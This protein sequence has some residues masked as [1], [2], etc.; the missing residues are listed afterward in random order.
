MKNFD[1]FKNKNN[2]FEVFKNFESITKY[3]ETIGDFIEL[4]NYIT[5]EEKY[6]VI[7][8]DYFIRQD[9]YTK[10]QIVSTINDEQVKLKIIFNEELRSKVL[11]SKNFKKFVNEMKPQNIKKILNNSKFSEEYKVDGYEISLWIKKMDIKDKKAI[12]NNRTL[13]NN[14]NISEGD[15]SEILVTINEDT[16]KEKY[17]ENVSFSDQDKCYIIKSFSSEYL[18]KFIENNK[19]FIERNHILIPKIFKEMKYEKISEII[20]NFDKLNIPE[21]DKKKILIMLN[22]EYKEKLDKNRIDNKFIKV[23]DL[24]PIEKNKLIPDFERDLSIYKGLDE[25]LYINPFEKD[26]TLENIIK[27][28]QICPNIKIHDMIDLEQS[29]VE[30]YIEGESWINNVLSQ[31]NPK[32][33]DIQKLAYIDNQIGKKISYT[34]NFDT[35]MENQSDERCC[36]KIISSGYGVCNGISIIEKYMLKKVGIESEKIDSIEHSFLKIKDIEIPTEN[37]IVKGDTLVDPTWNLAEQRYNARP[38]FFCIS[39][40]EIREADFNADGIDS[41]S[42]KV[43]E[44]EKNSDNIISLDD[45]YLREIYKSIGLVR[46]DNAFPIKKLLNDINK[47]DKS[48]YSIKEQLIQR[49][50]SLKSYYPDFFECINSTMKILQ[51]IVFRN[52]E[53]FDYNRCIV[54]RVYDKNDKNKKPILFTYFDFGQ[55]KKI[56]YYADK[57]TKNMLPLKQEDFEKRFEC[58]K[59]DKEKFNDKNMWNYDKLKLNENEIETDL[60]NNISKKYDEND[61][62]KEER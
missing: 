41:Y 54:S 51:C 50:D 19:D 33:T 20:Y 14:F 18:Y 49:I 31:I 52:S 15:I 7:H 37:G 55:N 36:W 2:K 58:Y 23:L 4:F 34:P 40:K 3:V 60:E 8:K 56:F 44:L 6:E 48:S 53:N 29:T 26:Y 21:E 10:S 1:E 46:D 13:L 32:W 57:E 25:I 11:D 27:L 24:K 28:S 47:I 16:Y 42:H 30:E 12:L 22:D 62:A 9:E 5:D 43:E 38:N 45:K 59:K 17:M 61:I 39:Y 35:E